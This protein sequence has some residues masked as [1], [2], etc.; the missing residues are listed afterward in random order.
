VSAD[1]RVMIR[2]GRSSEIEDAVAAW[3]AA[4]ESRNLPNHAD[5]LRAW[6]HAPDAVLHVADD[7]GALV[8]MA[9]RLVGRAD[10]GAGEPI[11]G[12]CHLTGIC[13]VP[14]L[15]GRHVGGRL[16]DVVLTAALS[17]GFTRVTL[18]T[19][20]DNFRACQLFEARGFRRTGR[21]TQD[22]HGEPM[23]H[24]ERDWLAGDPGG[25]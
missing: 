17:D 24:F 1:N 4:N 12:L 11:P 19:H 15:Q 22:E 7:D 16:V 9:L 18:W 5:R 20:R 14:A 3:I 10:D 23:L 8:G 25:T 6:C 21:V 2:R 13:V